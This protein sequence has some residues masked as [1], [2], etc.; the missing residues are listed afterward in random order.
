MSP[1]H[2][3]PCVDPEMKN[4]LAIQR[5]TAAITA[6]TQ[7]FQ[8]ITTD[9]DALT[10][11]VKK[12]NDS[13]DDIVLKGFEDLF[14][15]RMEEEA[16]ER[17]AGDEALKATCATLS[18][19]KADKKSLEDEIQSRKDA[20]LVLEEKI[21]AQD[22]LAAR[23]VDAESSERKCEDAKLDERLTALEGGSGTIT[24][25]IATERKERE[26]KDSELESKIAS[27]NS[28]LKEELTKKDAELESA[29]AKC[30]TTDELKSVNEAHANLVSY[31]DGLEKRIAVT[32]GMSSSVEGINADIVE[33]KRQLAENS[34]LISDLSARETKDYNSLSTRISNLEKTINDFIR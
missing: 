23:L 7:S 6:L 3:M 2:P 12:L 29:I 26:T 8:K 5:N 34:Q 22:G 13:L 11:D 21:K 31:V 17:K 1:C 19:T 25:Q 4:A 32:E 20:N 10:A 27:T 30:A 33:V 24:E 28:E 16:S 9:F 18:E 14:D 15:K